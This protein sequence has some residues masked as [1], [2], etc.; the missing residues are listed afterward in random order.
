MATKVKRA[1]RKKITQA[2]PR[3]RSVSHASSNVQERANPR[4]MQSFKVYRNAPPFMSFHITK[5]TIYWTVLL[6]IIFGIQIWILK[7]QLDI[8]ALTDAIL[9]Q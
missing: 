1:L 4:N 9:A 6:L 7:V 3:A 2:K 8:A 5:Q